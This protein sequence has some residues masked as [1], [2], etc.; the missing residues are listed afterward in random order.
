MHPHLYE[1]D[2]VQFTIQQNH[3]DARHQVQLDVDREMPRL[4]IATFA[5]R[6][7]AGIAA[8]LMTAGA[9][10]HRTPATSQESGVEQQPIA[11]PADTAVGL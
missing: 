6:L 1:L 11:E 9:Y 4:R 2:H 8:M 10:I 7:R 5:V 3:R